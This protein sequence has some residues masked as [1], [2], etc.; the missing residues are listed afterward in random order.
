MCT[1][2]IF[3]QN[4][5]N[6]V[7]QILAERAGPGSV[8][9]VTDRGPW[10][11]SYVARLK[12]ILKDAGYSRIK[13]FKKISSNP[14]LGECLA[15]RDMVRQK[16]KDIVIALGGGSVIDAAKHISWAAEAGFLMVIPTTAGTA[17]Y[18]NNWSVITEGKEKKS[19][20]TMAPSVALLDPVLTITVPP[21]LTLYT[22]LD[23]FSHGMEAY[24]S[25]GSNPASDRQAILGCEMVVE[26]LKDAIDDGEN[27][28]ARGNLFKADLLT[29]AAMNKAGLGVLHAIANIIPGFYP[30]YPHGYICGLMLKEVA[31]FNRDWVTE[32]KCDVILPL[33]EKASSIIAHF[34]S[35][36][37]L[38][39]GVIRAQDL[40][41]LKYLA[42]GNINITTN[43]RPV[44][45]GEMEYLLNRCFQLEK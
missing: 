27:I 2:V 15:G 9:L 36:M 28:V 3:G 32:E 45:E 8:I 18:I 19:F 10:L 14:T 44:H 17:S 16:G 43:P 39:L 37:E 34:S 35:S 13:E 42:L 6:E 24:F 29:G 21:H 7:G 25:S 30:V 5:L 31:C 23:C 12:K 11:D 38:P 41:K 1:Q 26:N 40:K 33:V 22:G 4:R 20:Q